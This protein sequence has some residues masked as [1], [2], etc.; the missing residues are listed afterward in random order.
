[1]K[2]KNH[3]LISTLMGAFISGCGGGGG[4]SADNIPPPEPKD[5][6]TAYKSQ[7]INWK[8]C[9][10]YFSKNTDADLEGYSILLGDRL[11]C[12][13][14]DAPL[15]Y[16]QPEKSSI[17]IAIIRVL[18]SKKS[19]K[20]PHLFFNPGGPGGDGHLDSIVYSSSLLA[21]GNENTPIGSIYRKMAENYN[22][23]GFSPRGVGASTTI[24]C[25]GNELFMPID[26]SPKGYN[27]ENIKN[28]TNYAKAVASNCQ[29]NP[30]SDYINTDATARDMDLMRHLLGDDKMHYYGTSYGTWLGFWYA[31]LFPE[32]IGPMVLDSNMNFSRPMNDASVLYK[33]GQI[34][35]FLEFQA[36]YI[37]RHDDLIGLGKTVDQVINNLNSMTDHAKSILG[38]ASYR[39]EPGSIAVNIAVL[40]TAFEVSNMEKQNSTPA[41][42]IDTI[43]NSLYIRD[44]MIRRAFEY[45]GYD[46]QKSIK[47]SIIQKLINDYN[48]KT[49]YAEKFSL[50]DAV[51]NTV[52]CNDEAVSNAD[53]IFWFRTGFS[54]AN[55]LP[56]ISADVSMQP[57]LYWKRNAA[58]T[59]PAIND[60]KAAKLMMVQ[61]QYDVPTPLSG[62]METF[63]QLPATSMVYVKNEGSHGLQF[64]GTECVDLTVMRYLL[65]QAPA[66]RMT[67]CE[68]KPMTL[69]KL[70]TNAA[71]TTIGQSKASNQTGHPDDEASNFEDPELA[72]KLIE[73]LRGAN[74]AAFH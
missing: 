55:R 64:Y 46:L 30:V 72:R 24:S 15:D 48:N 31:G 5:P 35:T 1:M 54:Q 43:K 14:I 37:S 70:A 29:K 42:I 26:Y 23:I 19:E 33:E 73:R 10:A 17:K 67:T 9:E 49:I 32:N 59:K 40:Q 12:A 2:F 60:L 36:P 62:A 38:H 57:C 7:K 11:Q 25:S 51:F 4:G 3:L 39:A 71:K 63:N 68:G 69:D 50:E 66:N 18:S 74:N 27:P 58:F 8:S 34:H 6:L 41:Q 45:E 20:N 53:P 65:G 22:F 44:N 16:S 52:V 47:N 56:I 61:S 28:I 21:M 13:D